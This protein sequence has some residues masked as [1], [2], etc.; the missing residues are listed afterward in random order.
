MYEL[1]ASDKLV[2]LVNWKKTKPPPPKP[3]NDQI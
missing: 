1:A 3:L 2:I